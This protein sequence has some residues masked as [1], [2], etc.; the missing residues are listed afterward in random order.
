MDAT[1]V[2]AGRFQDDAPGAAVAPQPAF[3]VV[4]PDALAGTAV[5]FG[6]DGLDAVEQMGFDQAWMPSLVLLAAP[7]H[8]AEVVAVPQN[9]LE[10]AH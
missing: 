1:G 10:L 5:T 6:E 2:T 9:L 8:V 3:E 7:E 4:V